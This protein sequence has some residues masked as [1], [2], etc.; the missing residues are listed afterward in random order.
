M[1]RLALHSVLVAAFAG[2]AA[3]ELVGGQSVNLTQLWRRD[4]ISFDQ[5]FTAYSRA[6]RGGCQ[7]YLNQDGLLDD[8]HQEAIDMVEAA[9]QGLDSYGDP[10]KKGRKVEMAARTFFGLSRRRGGPIPEDLMPDGEVYGKSNQHRAL[11]HS[12]I[13]ISEG[14]LD[15]QPLDLLLGVHAPQQRTRCF[16]RR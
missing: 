5:V 2:L 15:C 1:I 7:A 8:W 13:I 4:D 10:G 3:S 9:L 14:Y 16:T 11:D 6:D 12:G